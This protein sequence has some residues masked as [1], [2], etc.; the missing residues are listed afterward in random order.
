MADLTFST[1]LLTDLY[2]ALLSVGNVIP[3]MNA[4]G[5]YIVRRATEKAEKD[6][7]TFQKSE[8]ELIEKYAKRD[9]AG[10]LIAPTANARGG[11][12]YQLAD[13][14][15]FTAEREAMLAVEV[16]LTG[17]RA[18]TREELGECPITVNAEAALVKAGLLVEFVLP[19]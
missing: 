16:T 14:V 9:E 7:G 17:L 4:A 15:A 6:Y 2:H 3:S 8:Q 5:R 11:L 10:K 13:P 19:D 1:R 18:I 12:S